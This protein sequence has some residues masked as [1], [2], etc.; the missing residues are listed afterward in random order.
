MHSSNG[1]ID[2]HK[3]AVRCLD[4]LLFVFL[5]VL[6]RS[7]DIS[8]SRRQIGNQPEIW[9][10][11]VGVAISRGHRGG[12]SLGILTPIAARHA[13]RVISIMDNVTAP[14]YAPRPSATGPSRKGPRPSATSSEN[15]GTKQADSAIRARTRMHPKGEQLGQGQSAESIFTTGEAIPRPLFSKCLWDDIAPLIG[16]AW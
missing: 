15:E 9:L 1:C 13:A 8:Q 11:W 6:R 14:P 4:Y 7:I 10:G 5:S 16:G 12:R 3:T 2:P